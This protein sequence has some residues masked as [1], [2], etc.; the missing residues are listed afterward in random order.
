MFCIGCKLEAEQ[1]KLSV[2]G[3]E[4]ELGRGGEGSKREGEREREGHFK[5]RSNKPRQVHL[6]NMP[7]SLNGPAESFNLPLGGLMKTPIRQ[8]RSGHL[9]R[10]MGAPHFTKLFSGTD[11]VES[12]SQGGSGEEVE[13]VGG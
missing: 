2:G 7:P 4:G 8:A 1:S 11:H 6:E 10:V 9:T 5:R 13:G 3:G 12:T